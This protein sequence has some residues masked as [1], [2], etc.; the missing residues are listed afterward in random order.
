MASDADKNNAVQSH[1]GQ[2]ATSISRLR[3]ASAGRRETPAMIPRSPL[4]HHRC[5]GQVAIFWPSGN[6]CAHSALLSLGRVPARG[7]SRLSAVDAIEEHI[8]SLRRYA[9][10]L[11]GNAHDAD[12][13]VQECLLSAVARI[14]SAMAGDQMR[15]W[16]FT[17]LRNRFISDWRKA[18]ARRKDV[19]IDEPAAILPATGPNQ[20]GALQMR[21]LQRGLA[22]LPTEQREVLLLVALEGFGYL[23][24]AKMLDIPVGTVMSRLSRARDRLRGFMEGETRPKLRSVK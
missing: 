7:E 9:R 14:N 21:D 8:P 4:A 20:E 3:V 17:I 6:I 22:A 10:A 1:G 16:L 15:P 18:R 2:R 13:L 11:V 12:D 19:S 24:V 23:E 5:D